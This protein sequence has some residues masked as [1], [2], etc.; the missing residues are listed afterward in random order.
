MNI[1]EYKFCI[2]CENVDIFKFCIKFIVNK[3][4]WI[5]GELSNLS[6]MLSTFPTVCNKKI[7]S[8]PHSYTLFHNYTHFCT[9]GLFIYAAA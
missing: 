5:C 4:L 3:T 7:K 1:D 2:H 9:K 8:Y 6:T